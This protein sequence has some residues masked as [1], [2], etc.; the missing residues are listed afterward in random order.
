[1]KRAIASTAHPR[2]RGDQ[3]HGVG[4]RCRW[5]QL[6]RRPGNRAQRHRADRAVTTKPLAAMPNAG[7]PRAVEGRNIYLT[8]PEYMASF[9]RKLV[10]AGANLVGGCCGTTPSYTRAMRVPAC[11][12]GHGGWRSRE[13]KPPPPATYCQNRA[14]R[15][16]AALCQRSKIGAMSQRAVCHH[17]GDRPAQG[18]R[19]QERDRRRSDAPPL[20]RGRDQHSRLAARQARM[21][22]QSLCVQVQQQ[23][24]IE[25]SSTTPAA[26]V[27]CSA[28]RA[29]C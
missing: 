27:M 23:V 7:I 19:L 2:D 11:D 10:K 8:S 28:S 26:T 15:R 17:G 24:G 4:R 13:V 20:R 12:G 6:Q 9:T 18:D 16:A 25:T 14:R 22:A 21:S 29:T 3:A 1:M 5:L